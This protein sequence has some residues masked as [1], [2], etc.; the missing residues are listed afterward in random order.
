MFTIEDDVEKLDERVEIGNKENNINSIKQVYLKYVD[1]TEMMGTY[2]I[3]VDFPG[4]AY[5]DYLTNDIEEVESLL[6]EYG[7]QE[8][9][10]LIKNEK[11]H[12]RLTEREADLFYATIEPVLDIFIAPVFKTFNSLASM[13]YLYHGDNWSDVI[14]FAG[15]SDGLEYQIHLT[16]YEDD[17]RSTLW[18]DDYLALDIHLDERGKVTRIIKGQEDLNDFRKIDW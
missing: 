15:E 14:G 10:K 4:E 2:I 3:R 12:L 11:I 18:I 17:Y 7:Y 1:I 8:G 16:Y 9:F 5:Q 13:D 6:N